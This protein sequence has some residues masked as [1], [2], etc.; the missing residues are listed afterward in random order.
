MLL[1]CRSAG[2]LSAPSP[3]CKLRV[4]TVEKRPDRAE[5]AG[6]D[7]VPEDSPRSCARA[8]CRGA[9]VKDGRASDAKNY[10]SATAKPVCRSCT[11]S[12][13]AVVGPSSGIGGCGKV[14]F[15]R[16]TAE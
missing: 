3:S 15:V 11:W 6:P 9:D 16:A 13:V 2:K 12:L 1:A 5:Q 14:A 10:A 8:A 7:G 4:S